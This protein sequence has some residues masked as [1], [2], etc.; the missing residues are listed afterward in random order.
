MNSGADV[1]FGPGSP[2]RL[3]APALLT[4]LADPAPG[5]GRCEPRTPAGSA[6]PPPGRADAG[7]AAAV[8]RGRVRR[9]L[10]SWPGR[11][12]R[13]ADPIPLAPAVGRRRLR[14]R[15]V[16]AHPSGDPG[17]YRCRP[18]ARARRG[19]SRAA[20]AVRST[21]DRADL[22]AAGGLDVE[23]AL[24]AKPARRGCRS[25]DGLRRTLTPT[26]ALGAGGVVSATAPG[27]P[28]LVDGR[29]LA[30]RRG[31]LPVGLRD[32]HLPAAAVVLGGP[33]A[34]PGAQPALVRAA[35]GRR[36]AGHPAAEAPVP[37]ARLAALLRT[38]STDPPERQ[39]RALASAGHR[40]PAARTR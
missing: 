5:S 7:Q 31:E 25:E 22:D 33:G 21:P 8:L 24:P 37:P 11:P 40:R 29:A 19:Q 4:Q 27:D 35:D 36:P 34:Q 18:A 14:S 6:T 15:P 38:R 10:Q 3:T 20:W 1:L 13:H 16:P 28:D 17:R 12:R 26:E 39:H 9:L 23:G 30:D 2:S 32:R